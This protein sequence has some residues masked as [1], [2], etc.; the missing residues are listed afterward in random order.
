MFS[1]ESLMGGDSVVLVGLTQD[2][3]LGSDEAVGKEPLNWAAM[4][5]SSLVDAMALSGEYSAAALLSK[6]VLFYIVQKEVH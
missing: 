3:T 4:S 5:P 2:E 1:S 6:I